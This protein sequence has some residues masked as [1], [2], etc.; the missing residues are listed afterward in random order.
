MPD[1]TQTPKL[2]RPPRDIQEGT[3][4]HL[5]MIIDA[6]RSG[7]AR[8]AEY[9]ATDLLDQLVCRALLVC[10]RNETPG[11]HEGF[12]AGRET[13]LERSRR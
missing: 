4:N 7:N 2:F 9:L 3:A 5:I 8:E 1:N 13:E 6:C 12:K 11:Y 10:R